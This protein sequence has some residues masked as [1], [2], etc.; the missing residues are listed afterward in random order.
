MAERVE[1]CKGE[2]LGGSRPEEN[3]SKKVIRG[4]EKRTAVVVGAGSVI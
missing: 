4:E 1:R 3:Q 2:K